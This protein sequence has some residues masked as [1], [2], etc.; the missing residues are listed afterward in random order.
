MGGD[1]MKNIEEQ[2]VLHEGLRLDPYHCTAGKLTIGVGRNL[3]DVGIS[4]DEAMLLL[5]HDIERVKVPLEKLPWFNSLDP[6]R[7]KV[8]VDMAFNLGY[9][10]LMGFKRTIAAIERKDYA[11]ASYEMMNSRWARQV[12]RRASRLAEMMATGKDYE[13]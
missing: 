7:Q 6:V 10:G 4:R 2:L 13:R 1:A 3:D 11:S 8:I 9:A 12:G 5:Q